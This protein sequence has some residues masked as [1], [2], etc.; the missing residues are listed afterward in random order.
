M[1]RAEQLLLDCGW[2]AEQ[3]ARKLAAECGCCVR[4]AH[5]YIRA[6]RAIYAHAGNA[7]DALPTPFEVHVQLASLAAEARSAAEPDYKAAVKA[8]ELSMRA[9][10]WLDRKSTVQVNVNGTV[11]HIPALQG[12]SDAEIAALQAYHAAL[13]ARLEAA[14]IDTTAVDADASDDQ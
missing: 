10:G 11:T 4:Q 13:R 9:R 7:S 1:R 12:A 6:V 2:A 5:R 8:I 14:P 3:A